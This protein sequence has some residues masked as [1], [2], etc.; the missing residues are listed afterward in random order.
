MYPEQCIQT[1]SFWGVWYW[2]WMKHQAVEVIVVGC[3][4]MSLK[5]EY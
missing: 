4:K 3:H 1:V 5:L 2:I